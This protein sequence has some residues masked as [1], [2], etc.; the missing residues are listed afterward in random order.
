[1][2]VLKRGARGDDV[3]RLQQL[4]QG[5]GFDPGGVDGAFG[6]RT[7]QAVRAFQAAQGLQADGVVGTITWSALLSGGAIIVRPEVRWFGARRVEMWH[8]TMQRARVRPRCVWA[9]DPVAMVAELEARRRAGSNMIPRWVRRPLSVLAGQSVLAVNSAFFD[10]G[11]GWPLGPTI[12][13]GRP[14]NGGMARPPEEFV[15][16]TTDPGLALTDQSTSVVYDLIARGVRQAFS[17]IPELIRDGR[18]QIGGHLPEHHGPAPRSLLGWSATE[19]H[20]IVADGRSW[21]SRGLSLDEAAD[22]L[23]TAGCTEAVNL[24]SGGS[25][26][27]VLAGEVVNRPSDGSERPLPAGLAFEVI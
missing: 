26:E 11:N 13:A 20:A 4:L 21:R 22:L 1:M 16:V 9:S 3:R 15:V 6:P 12:E 10:L 8:A 7:D 19:I 27:M 18:R 5:A 25:A 14:I 24:D 17:T 23:L 2:R